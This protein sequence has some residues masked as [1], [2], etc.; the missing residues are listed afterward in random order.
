MKIGDLV[1]LPLKNSR[2]I[3]IG[4]I[5]SDYIFDEKKKPYSH[6]RKVEW[7]EK[8][9]PRTSFDQD[10]LYSFGAFKTFCEINRNDAESRIKSFAILTDLVKSILFIC[11]L[12]FINYHKTSANLL[13]FTP[14]PSPSQQTSTRISSFGCYR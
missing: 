14:S 7:I 10:L 8:E 3:A 12:K 6:I 9:I 11:K 13:N 5:V 4:K 2:K 1:I